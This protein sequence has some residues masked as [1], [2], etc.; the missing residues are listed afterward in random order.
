MALIC[1][2]VVGSAYFFGR[3][4]T[5]PTKTCSSLRAASRETREPQ[6]GAGS[7]GGWELG[8]A[9]APSTQHP[10][11]LGLGLGPPGTPGKFRQEV[12]RQRLAAGGKALGELEVRSKSAVELL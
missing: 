3:E 10:Q 1:Y 12:Q 5:A 6:V 8:A 7:T 11:I 2:L 9:A 4:P